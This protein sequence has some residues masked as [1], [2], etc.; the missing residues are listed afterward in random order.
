M[1]QRNLEE[2]AAVVAV[3]PGRIGKTMLVPQGGKMELLAVGC[4]CQN[5]HVQEDQVGV[6]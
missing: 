5:R 3:V 2:E 4:R 1:Q 6:S